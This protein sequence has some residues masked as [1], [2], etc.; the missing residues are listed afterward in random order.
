MTITS[1]KT[2]ILRG[3]WIEDGAHI[4]AA[5]SNAL[6]RA[7]LDL[8][9]VRRAALVSVDSK[10]QAQIECGDLVEPV[11]Q[12]LVRWDDVREL[13]EVIAGKAPGRSDARSVT[14]FESQGLA[15]QDVAVGARV[16]ER[17]RQQSVGREIDFGD[18][19]A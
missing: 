14:L 19:N 1:S 15:M 10:E 3:E 13:G 2:P 16:L 11:R 9:A 6:D 8:A 5:G 12:G 18:G 17:A 7:E 4:N